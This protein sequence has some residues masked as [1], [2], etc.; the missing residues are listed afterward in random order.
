M[1]KVTFSW[2]VG[3]TYFIYCS[4]HFKTSASAVDGMILKASIVGTCVAGGFPGL[5]SGKRD[6]PHVKGRL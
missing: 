4:D 6:L 1:L 5:L 3:R 2:V